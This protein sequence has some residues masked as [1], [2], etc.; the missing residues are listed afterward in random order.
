MHQIKQC[1]QGNEWLWNRTT[2]TQSQST[3]VKV[4]TKSDLYRDLGKQ[5]NF[6]A[7]IFTDTLQRIDAILAV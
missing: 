2:N 6:Q 7:Q 3:R 4:T 5:H 1:A